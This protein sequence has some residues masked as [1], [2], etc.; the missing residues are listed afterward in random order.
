MYLVFFDFDKSEI[1]A[2]GQNVLDAVAEE[3]R[4]RSLNAVTIV[5]HTD[6]AGPKSY[7]NKLAMRRANSVRDALI[8]RGVNASL[9][10]VE[11]R[12]EDNL[13]VQTADG[14]REPANRRAQITFD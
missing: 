10:R 6:A 2:G 8:Q 7:N 9:I 1:G 5:G 11:G 13:L 12:G 3:I 14:V 4:S